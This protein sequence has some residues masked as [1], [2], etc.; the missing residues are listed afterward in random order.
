[1]K[2][3]RISSIPQ[4]KQRYITAGD[5]FEVEGVEEIRVTEMHD[6]RMEF[7]IGLHE[8][9][10]WYLTEQRGIKESDIS[11]FD[12]QFEEDRAKGLHTEE[13]EPGDDKTAPYYR[14]HQFASCIE[15]LMCA[16]LGISWQEYEREQNE[17]IKQ[18]G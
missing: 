13:E 1:M 4:E 5:Y 3:I 10:E 17:I 18:Y 16:E 14:E 8:M 7:L 6:D 11:K 15:R 12:I 2:E 9:V